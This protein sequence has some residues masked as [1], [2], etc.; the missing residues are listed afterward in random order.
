MPFG[1]GSVCRCYND[2]LSS[3]LDNGYRRIN[4]AGI[5]DY[6]LRRNLSL[7]N[8]IVQRV[9]HLDDRISC[10]EMQRFSVC[11]HDC[12]LPA[13][14]HAGIYHRMTV[15][16][17]LRSR[18]Y[19]NPQNSDLGLPLRIHRQKLPIPALGSFNEFL[20]DWRRLVRL[21]TDPNDGAQPGCK[22]TITERAARTRMVC[23]I[24]ELPSLLLDFVSG[25]HSAMPNARNKARGI[26]PHKKATEP[27]PRR[28]DL[29][30]MAQFVFICSTCT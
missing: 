5:K 24:M 10:F 13:Y 9:H 20:D 12:E 6:N 21:R 28:L 8:A 4:N 16:M 18:R 1:Y 11:S 27:N 7:I 29:F 26:H 30:V 25:A 22:R 14:Q 3:R 15:S 23:L 19:A 17:E 2:T